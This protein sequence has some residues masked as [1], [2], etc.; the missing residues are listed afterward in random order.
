MEALADL[1]PVPGSPWFLV[2]KVDADES[3]AEVRYRAGIVTL[4]VSLGL[5]LAAAATAGAYRQR[6]AGLYRD[7]Y[8]AEREQRAA[9]ETFRMT[10]YSIGDAVITTDSEGRVRQMNPVAEQ[11]TGWSEAEA[12][13]QTLDAVFRIVNEGT[14][15][16]VENPAQRVLREGTVVGLANHTLFIARDGTER[17][18]S[19]SGAPIRDER[20]AITGVV[21]VFHDQTEER[22]ANQALRESERRFR[23]AVMEAPFPVMIYAEDGEVLT[24]SLSLIHI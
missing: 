14:H 16:V 12:R 23:R 24:L 10:L 7:R 22:A 4:F 1:R 11:L 13:G 6:Q 9:Q 17:P 19:D 2:A 20:G 15:A 21:L 5:L 8:Q 18:I 3:L